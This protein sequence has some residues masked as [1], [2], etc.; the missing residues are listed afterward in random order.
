M[1]T[2]LTP[3]EKPCRTRMATLACA[4]DTEPSPRRPHDIIA[5]PGGRHGHRTLPPRPRATAK[6]LAGSVRHDPAEV[7]AAAF[8]QAEARDPRHQR[9][10]V[11]LADG[12]EHQ[13]DLIRAEAQRRGVT[14]HI[15]TGLIHV[16]EYIWKAA[17]CLHSPGD[18][19]AE[20]WVAV[21]ALAVLAGD[22]TRAAAEI[23]TETQ[24]AG[25]TAAQRAAPTP[26]SAISPARTSSCATTRRWPRAGPSRPASSKEHAGI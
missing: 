23:T 15:V 2:R 10:W 8:S 6:W 20:D 12:A 17:W 22:S 18:P 16:L 21:K 7:I 5:P 9:T 24:T 19:A 13:L 4:C 1:R 14:I 11:V 25:L 26:A 3:G